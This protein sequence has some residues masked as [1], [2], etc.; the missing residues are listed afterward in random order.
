MGDN[1][2]AW[3]YK[4]INQSAT[5][6]I[7]LFVFIILV[8]NLCA[9]FSACSD[10]NISNEKKPH[11][12]IS[13]SLLIIINSLESPEES[14]REYLAL[15][16]RN[17]RIEEEGKIQIYIKLYEID[18]SKLEDLKKHGLTI[19]IYDNKEKLVQGWVLP[20]QIKIISELPYVKFVDLPTYGVSN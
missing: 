6:T 15:K 19:D 7:R 8:T 4:D 18:E 17:F 14:K 1:L 9:I 11:Q 16:Y 3:T 5:K 20:S 2:V 10:N 12:K 13:P